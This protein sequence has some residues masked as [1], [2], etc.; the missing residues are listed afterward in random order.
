MKNKILLVLFILSVSIFSQED[1]IVGIEE[2][3]DT[4]GEDLAGPATTSATSGLTWSDA[5]IGN[6]PH[7]GVGAFTSTVFIPV[8]GFNDFLSV[9]G[10]ASGETGAELPAELTQIPVGVP[11]PAV[12]L[13]GRLGGF[14]IPFDLGVKF[15]MLDLDIGSNANINYLLVG[16]DFRYGILED[17][18]LLP[19]LS[20][21]VGYSKLINEITLTGLLGNDLELVAPDSSGLNL[22]NGL[23][24]DDPDV[25]F[26]WESDVI[27]AKL[28]IS[29]KI[30]GITPYLGANV[31]YGFTT[32]SGGLETSVK[33]GNGNTLTQNEIDT[34]IN[35]ANS[36]P[37]VDLPSVNASGF[38]TSNELEAMGLKVNL[39]TS[40]NILLL[41]IDLSA[42]YDVL[43]DILGTQLG[44]R[45]QF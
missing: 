30:L 32:V 26:G 28:Q 15:A 42:N 17:D 38:T 23:Y 37:G 34:I 45:I 13:D 39:G 25:S 3:F 40:F 21:G 10:E 33:D 36:V 6:F 4:L 20:I 44:F 24:L 31:S 41:R 22:H 2:Q 7:F 14:V 11:L 8:D 1:F 19:G 35:G 27:E 9:A 29:K 18:G 43:N 5:Y 16:G 12:G